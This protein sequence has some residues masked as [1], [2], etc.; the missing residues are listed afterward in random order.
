LS[1]DA[2]LTKQ[3]IDKKKQ[4]NQHGALNFKSHTTES[5]SNGFEP[6]F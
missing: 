5:E 4:K 6:E 3:L 2:A 1:V